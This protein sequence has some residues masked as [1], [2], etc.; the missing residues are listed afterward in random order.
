[1]EV[2]VAVLCKE[3]SQMPQKIMEFMKSYWRTVAPTKVVPLESAQSKTADI[4][5]LYPDKQ[6]S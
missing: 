5:N 3:D 6:E 2:L 4:A 1:M